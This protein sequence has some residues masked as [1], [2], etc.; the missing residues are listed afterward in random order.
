M[1]LP[2][3]PSLRCRHRI[4]DKVGLGLDMGHGGFARG[5]YATQSTFY[6]QHYFPVGIKDWSVRLGVRN[7]LK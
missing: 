2:F 7:A 5:K 4:E 1:H 3:Q 6:I